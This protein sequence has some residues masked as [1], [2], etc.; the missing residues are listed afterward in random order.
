MGSRSV[1]DIRRPEAGDL[2]EAQS[3]VEAMPPGVVSPATAVN[4]GVG[5]AAVSRMVA[6]RTPLTDAAKTPSDV[7]AIPTFA[8]VDDL[9]RVRLI[10]I[11]LDQTWVGPDDELALESIWRSLGN[12]DHLVSFIEAYPGLWEKCIDRG[13]DLTG[14]RPYRDIKTHFTHDI[15]A[16]ARRYC[17]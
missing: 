3:Q 1:P 17:I 9:E 13:A 7:K 4:A 11:L 6:Q 16:L 2:A 10:N 12:E 5:N 8:G 15:I 14:I